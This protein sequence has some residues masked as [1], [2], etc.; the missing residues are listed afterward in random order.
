M[1]SLKLSD[2]ETTTRH[3]FRLIDSNS[4]SFVFD[5]WIS[6]KFITQ[7]GYHSQHPHAGQYAL[8][9]SVITEI[10]KEQSIIKVEWWRSF[11]KE[12]W[13]I[14]VNSEQGHGTLDINNKFLKV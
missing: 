2:F 10:R 1:E 14:F 3:Y 6:S 12:F 13:Q 9:P 8:V 5:I 4:F 7:V 11:R